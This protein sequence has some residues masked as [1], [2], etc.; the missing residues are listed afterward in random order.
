MPLFGDLFE[1]V[2]TGAGSKGV[3]KLCLWLEVILIIWLMSNVTRQSI[4]DKETFYSVTGG[5]NGGYFL[6]I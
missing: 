1:R 4:M 5:K 3:W 2:V 6:K